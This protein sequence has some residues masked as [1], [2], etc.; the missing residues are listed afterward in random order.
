VGAAQIGDEIAVPGHAHGC[1]ILADPRVGDLDGV[2]VGA[3]HLVVSVFQLE[4]A[5]FPRP[6]EFEFNHRGEIIAVR[7]PTAKLKELWMRRPRSGGA[8]P[9]APGGG[10]GGGGGRAG[11]WG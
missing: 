1:V 10:G 9:E 4:E 11:G 8:T 5:G 7:G 3:A 2:V 6:D